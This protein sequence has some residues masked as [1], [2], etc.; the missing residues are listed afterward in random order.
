MIIPFSR[1]AIVILPFVFNFV[2]L[3]YVL[4]TKPSFTPPLNTG[5]E[6]QNR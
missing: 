6:N 3:L 5:R 1:L 4:K 2:I